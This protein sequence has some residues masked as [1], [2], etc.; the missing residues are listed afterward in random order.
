M[1][2]V[3]PV[4]RYA[5]AC[6]VLVVSCLFSDAQDFG[7]YTEGMHSFRLQCLE[8][9][10]EKAIALCDML[11]G[12]LEKRFPHAKGTTIPTYGVF[13]STTRISAKNEDAHFTVSLALT[14]SVRYRNPNMPG[15]T[16]MLASDLKRMWLTPVSESDFMEW[17]KAHAE[18]VVNF[19]NQDIASI[20]RSK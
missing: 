3:A 20:Q 18:I 10:D 2:N 13:V 6:V 8:K 11:E 17:S 1:N 7:N 12:Q 5:V 15:G 16:F 9:E 14:R 19:M 4:A